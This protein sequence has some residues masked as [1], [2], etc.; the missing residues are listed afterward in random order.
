MDIID[1]LF[2]FVVFILNRLIGGEA[3][4]SD[5]YQQVHFPCSSVRG[6]HHADS[7]GTSSSIR[8]KMCGGIVHLASPPVARCLEYPGSDAVTPGGAVFHWHR[9]DNLLVE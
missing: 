7:Q 3:G 2:L 5:C 8:R 1:F 4:R 6:Q 9:F